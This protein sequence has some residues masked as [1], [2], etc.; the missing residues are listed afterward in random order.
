MYMWCDSHM[1]HTQKNMQLEKSMKD[2][3]SEIKTLE[4]N[5]LRIA[6]TVGIVRDIKWDQKKYARHRLDG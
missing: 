3:E 6:S 1:I 2:T 5:S 4:K